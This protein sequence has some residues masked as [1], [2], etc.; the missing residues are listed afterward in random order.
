MDGIDF[1][2]MAAELA[3]QCAGPSVPERDVPEGELRVAA[4]AMAARGYRHSPASLEALRR[5]LQG[6]GLYLAGAVGTGK[7]L[8]FRTVQPT[9]TRGNPQGR[10]AILSMA[11][12]L[13]RS[14]ADVAAFLDGNTDHELVLDDVGR[15]PQFVEY[16]KRFE[17]L[18]WIL[19]RREACAARTHVTTNG[20]EREIAARYGTAVVDR[21]RGLGAYIRFSGPSLRAPRPKIR[22]PARKV[23]ATA[24][25]SPESGL[26]RP[27]N[28]P[29]GP[30][31]ANLGADARNA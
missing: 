29:Q 4:A 18:P 11:G 9:P 19:D 23:A 16:G 14:V 30:G 25:E 8:F 28:T 20:S 3:A 1:E 10:V 27:R 21:L 2:R 6:Y 26:K 5:Y 13:D 31:A 7:T 15:E 22:F 17:I 24:P 12:L